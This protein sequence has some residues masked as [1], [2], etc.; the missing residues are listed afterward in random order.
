MSIYQQEDGSYKRWPP[1]KGPIVVD[2]Y[3]YDEQGPEHDWGVNKVVNNYV[4]LSESSK[5]K[6]FKAVE[7]GDVETLKQL[8][9]SPDNDMDQQDYFGYTALHISTLSGKHGTERGRKDPDRIMCCELLIQ[10]GANLNVHGQWGQTPLQ[11]AA[12]SGGYPNF[13]CCKLLVD[14]RADILEQDQW[15]RNPLH[16]AASGASFLQLQELLLHPDAEEAKKTRDDEGKTPLV[17]AHEKKESSF[18]DKLVPVNDF[19]IQLL[20]GTY[21]N[22]AIDADGNPVLL[23]EGKE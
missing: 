3:Q 4:P 1:E 7:A 22:D 20:E 8:L 23:K 11:V 21:K 2:E 9:N 12:C 17:T 15:G 5:G 16:S 10:A 18:Y 14:A 13:E 19:C 6:V